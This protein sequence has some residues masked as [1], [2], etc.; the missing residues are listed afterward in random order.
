VLQ[1][2]HA[3]VWRVDEGGHVEY[4]RALFGGAGHCVLIVVHPQTNSR[5]HGPNSIAS[6]ERIRIGDVD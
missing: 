5:H 3:G 2:F 4:R 6:L 1:M